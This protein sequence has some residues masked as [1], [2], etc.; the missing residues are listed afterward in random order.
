MGLFPKGLFPEL[1][2]AGL[3]GLGFGL[4]VLA[5]GLAAA[6][7]VG[8]GVGLGAGGPTKSGRE[9]VSTWACNLRRSAWVCPVSGFSV[10]IFSA[11]SPI[12]VRI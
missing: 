8:V 3:F 2:L 10:P 7:G 6:A 12:F 11:S 4:F 1:P 5:A 9:V